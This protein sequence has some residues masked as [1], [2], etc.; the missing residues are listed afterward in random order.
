MISA[1]QE[2]RKS[3]KKSDNQAN[4]AST[5]DALIYPKLR[6]YFLQCAMQCRDFLSEKDRQIADK[7]FKTLEEKKVGQRQIQ[8]NPPSTPSIAWGDHSLDQNQD[9]KEVKELASPALDAP[10]S[11]MF[12][13]AAKRYT[14]DEKMLAKRCAYIQWM[15]DTGGYRSGLI[16]RKE[17]EL[18]FLKA[19]L[20]NS[21]DDTPLLERL[22]NTKILKLSAYNACKGKTKRLIDETI[23]KLKKPIAPKNKSS[24]K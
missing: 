15:L 19:V 7:A 22:E 10:R 9:H 4:L 24:S 13:P 6:I 2:R 12:Q 14:G 17:K 1:C 8:E 21:S 5:E 3:Y 23:E 16:V 11:R 18:E 20:T